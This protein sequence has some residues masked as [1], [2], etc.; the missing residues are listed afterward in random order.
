MAK[1]LYVQF[2]DPDNC[3]AFNKMKV[4]TITNRMNADNIT[5][6]PVKVFMEGKTIYGIS[7]I[8]NST[9]EKS[10]SV[11]CGLAFGQEESWWE[12]GGP[13]PDGSFSLFRTKDN[14]TE[15]VSDA[16]ASR[17]TWYYHDQD[18]FAASSS[19]RAIISLIGDF[20]LNHAVFPW[21]LSTGSLGPGLSWDRRIKLLSPDSSVLLDH[22]TWNLEIKCNEVKFQPE[23]LPD[24]VHQ[25]KLFAA[26]RD[27]FK[28][29][30]LDFKSWVLPLSGGYDSRGILCLLHN[31]GLNIKQL[32][33]ITWGMAKAISK[34]GNDAFIAKK[35]ANYFKIS[36][37]YYPTDVSDEP[38]E[39]IFG[40]FL[41]CGEGRIDHIGGY[42]DG[43]KTW[44]DLFNDN[45]QGIVRGDEGFGLMKVT[46]PANVR[47]RLGIS[48]CSDFP[49]L[50]NYE[51]LGL[52]TQAMPESLEKR[53]EETMETWRDR[54]YHQFRMPV[55]LSALTEL[56]L[57]FT[58]VITPFLSRRIIYQTRNMP[59]HLRTEK[60]AYRKIINSLSPKIEYATS[61]ANGGSGYS[62]KSKRAV[63]IIK[64]E[65]SSA[66][67]RLIL[68]AKLLD[69]VLKNLKSTRDRTNRKRNIQS[70]IKRFLPGRIL[71]IITDQAVNKDLAVHVLA[72]RMFIISRMNQ[73]LEQDVEFSREFDQKEFQESPI[74]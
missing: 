74:L 49:N 35:V 29:I 71:L 63:E 8:S 7:N 14:L 53:Q 36:H 67:C 48:L 1:I 4:K 61:N 6:R 18:V 50:A 70:F 9:K 17:A 12:P 39:Q 28:A 52:M 27:T 15:I 22:E 66:H 37:K 72:F 64:A 69:Y 60:S 10:Q 19:Q 16:A 43:F 20:K 56:K 24:K 62:V 30:S 11:L 2:R 73:I 47:F 33:T 46:T 59:D 42:M 38:L 3:N 58:E 32:K 34:P 31:S 68:P 5:P 57:P 13:V 55:V 65:L 25:E 26:L 41:L 23:Q 44:A 40:R 54:L 51:E 45:I 21:M